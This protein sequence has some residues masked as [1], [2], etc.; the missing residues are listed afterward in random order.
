MGR[1][2]L[3]IDPQE[4]KKERDAALGFAEEE[5]PWVEGDY[6]TKAIDR[7]HVRALA[8]LIGYCIFLCFIFCVVFLNPAEIN[9]NRLILG[10]QQLLDNSDV[11]TVEG[12]WDFI[13]EVTPA[14]HQTTYD[15]SGKPLYNVTPG[16]YEPLWAGREGMA[17]GRVRLRQLRLAG[18]TCAVPA[19]F[20]GKIGTCNGPLDAT[21]LKRDGE[22]AAEGSF[23][24]GPYQTHG[25]G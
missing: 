25:D 6:K 22:Y 4:E 21:R 8:D 17:L 10:L 11:T 14:L 9:A 2:D 5:R 19:A 23:N 16:E 18:D 7:Q 24:S 3:S 12:I 15:Y 13:G 1:G 20:A